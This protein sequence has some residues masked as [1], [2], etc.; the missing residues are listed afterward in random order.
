[1]AKKKKKTQDAAKPDPFMTLGGQ[2]LEYARNNIA[3]VGLFCILL[4]AGAAFALYWPQLKE[5]RELEAATKLLEA[6]SLLKDANPIAG[7]GFSFGEPKPEDLKKALEVYERVA[8]EHPGM[9][10]GRRALVSAGDANLKL[11]KQASK[12]VLLCG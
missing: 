1:M 9:A 8:K 4:V 10:A 2:G 6:A 5:Q 3:V 11:A 12:Q 7:L